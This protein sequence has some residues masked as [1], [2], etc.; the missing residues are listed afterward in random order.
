M[1]LI[2]RPL[3]MLNDVVAAEAALAHGVR[4]YP[5]SPL[6]QATPPSP[7][8][9]LGYAATPEQAIAPALQ[10]LATALL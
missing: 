8:L 10:R 2:A 5:L 7:G 9:I 3:A 1:H 4:V 6:Y